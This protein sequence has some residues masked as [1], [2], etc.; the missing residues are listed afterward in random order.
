MREWNNNWNNTSLDERMT[1]PPLPTPHCV[2]LTHFDDRAIRLDRQGRAKKTSIGRL[3][4]KHKRR[5]PSTATPPSGRG[6][7]NKNRYEE[8]R[9]NVANLTHSFAC[10]NTNHAISKWGIHGGFHAPPGLYHIFY[11]VGSITPGY[12]TLQLTH[13]ASPRCTPSAFR[14]GNCIWSIK[15]STEKQMRKTIY[16]FSSRNQH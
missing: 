9:W 15:T 2:I 13:I 5:T 11:V 1:P 14:E 3:L 6:R 12:A 7:K 8:L 16:V 4:K 10:C